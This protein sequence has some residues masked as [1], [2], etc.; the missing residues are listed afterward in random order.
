MGVVLLKDE[1]MKGD[2]EKRFSD[3]SGFSLGEVEKPGV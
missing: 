1:R 3:M 2:E